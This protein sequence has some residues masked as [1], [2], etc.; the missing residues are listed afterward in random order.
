MLCAKQEAAHG[1][2]LVTGQVERTGALIVFQN[3]VDVNGSIS[4]T[5][6]YNRFVGCPSGVR[7]ASKLS[8]QIASDRC[9]G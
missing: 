4:Q 2:D 6:F 9:H 3:L 5:W 7:L 1:V 8:G